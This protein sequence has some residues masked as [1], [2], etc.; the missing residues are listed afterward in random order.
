MEC[1]WTRITDRRHHHHQVTDYNRSLLIVSPLLEHDVIIFIF[2]LF[3]AALFCLSRNRPPSNSHCR[4]TRWNQ[5]ELL[6]ILQQQQKSQNRRKSKRQEK[7]KWSRK[8]VVIF[9]RLHFRRSS[10][11]AANMDVSPNRKRSISKSLFPTA[12]V[13][14]RP[15]KKILIFFSSWLLQYILCDSV[16]GE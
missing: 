8:T 15:L 7:K 4:Q 1:L 12:A 2:F 5:R 11:P 3:L 14:Q 13:V 16:A 9:A 6:H 10:M